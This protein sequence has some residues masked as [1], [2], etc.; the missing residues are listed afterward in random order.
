MAGL[1]L[2]PGGDGDRPSRADHAA[3]LAQCADGS[4]AYFTEL[5]AGRAERVVGQRAETPAV[6]RRVPVPAGRPAPPTLGVQSPTVDDPSGYPYAT[7]HIGMCSSQGIRKSPSSSST[8]PC[9]SGATDRSGGGVPRVALGHP[10]SQPRPPGSSPSAD[11]AGR[12]RR[13]RSSP[14]RGAVLWRRQVA[15]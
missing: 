6:G 3:Q 11:G 15:V 7:S 9:R 1:G 12:T 4:A 14:A 13:P 8:Q 10:S 5:N 2:A